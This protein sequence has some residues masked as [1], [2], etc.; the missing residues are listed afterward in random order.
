MKIKYLVSLTSKT[1]L[2][3]YLDKKNLSAEEQNFVRRHF[4]I[5]STSA[6]VRI[7]LDSLCGGLY[8]RVLKIYANILTSINKSILVRVFMIFRT[9]YY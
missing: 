9:I 5:Y 2:Q 6:E 7:I 3:I 8:I 1:I 4:G